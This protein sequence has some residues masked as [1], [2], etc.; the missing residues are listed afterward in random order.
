MT[1]SDVPSNTANIL[2][3]NGGGESNYTAIVEKG[4]YDATRRPT[5]LEK[6]K[7]AG[8]NIVPRVTSLHRRSPSSPRR[9]RTSSPASSRTCSATSSASNEVVDRS[10]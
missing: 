2:A 9:S 5:M 8:K 4:G 10:I 7:G 3:W 6:V 1:S